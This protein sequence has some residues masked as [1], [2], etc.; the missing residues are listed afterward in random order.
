LGAG[1]ELLQ[2]AAAAAESFGSTA[3]RLQPLQMSKI[4]SC[5]DLARAAAAAFFSQAVR[6]HHHLPAMER[7][8]PA[9][10]VKLEQDG[11]MPL[12]AV[13]SSAAAGHTAAAA[14]GVSA[15]GLAR[16]VSADLAASAAAATAGTALKLGELGGAA[17]AASA[18]VEAQES[19]ELENTLMWLQ[20][21]DDQVGDCAIISSSSWLS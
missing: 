17:G 13:P 16:Q 7:N 8:A 5:P 1:K 15:A 11:P 6:E 3:G 21:A 10:A 14:A 2:P 12:T 4:H 20:S 19:E 9:V 18:V